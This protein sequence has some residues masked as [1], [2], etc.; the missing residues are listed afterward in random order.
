MRRGFLKFPEKKNQKPPKK[1]NNLKYL[2]VLH[3][4]HY[5]FELVPSTYYQTP[6]LFLNDIMIAAIDVVE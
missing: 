3:A 6:N 4:V 2:C 5:S 1:F